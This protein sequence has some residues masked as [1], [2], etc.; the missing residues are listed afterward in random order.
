MGACLKFGTF[1][2]R[3]LGLF[4]TGI[5]S[6]EKLCDCCRRRIQE[7]EITCCRRRCKRAPVGFPL[8]ANVKRVK[9]NVRS[10]EKRWSDKAFSASYNEK[11]DTVEKLPGLSCLWAEAKSGFANFD[12]IPDF[13][14]LLL[15]VVFEGGG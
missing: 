14:E 5:L 7:S 15:K 6:L 12:L 2:G 13:D 10:A 8:V 3:V 1:G 9:S 4:E 11:L